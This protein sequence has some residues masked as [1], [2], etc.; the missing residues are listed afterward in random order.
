MKNSEA[1][2]AKI[3]LQKAINQ[4]KNTIEE[5]ANKDIIEKSIAANKA[6]Q[7]PKNTKEDDEEELFFNSYS[8]HTNTQVLDQ[9]DELNSVQQ[10]LYNAAYQAHQTELAGKLKIVES[11]TRQVIEACT[12][13]KGAGN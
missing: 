1:K 9:L 7:I 2:A 3:T 4:V 12:K 10:D 6:A 8:P 13:A 11:K 5:N